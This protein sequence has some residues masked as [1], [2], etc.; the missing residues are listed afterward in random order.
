MKRRRVDACLRAALDDKRF[1]SFRLSWMNQAFDH[2]AFLRVLLFWCFPTRVWQNHR[3]DISS[4]CDVCWS[5]SA[6]SIWFLSCVSDRISTTSAFDWRCHQ[7]F[8]FQ[9]AHE[10][11]YSS[12]YPSWSS[13]VNENLYSCRKKTLKWTRIRCYCHWTSLK[14]IILIN[15]L[16][17]NCRRCADNVSRFNWHV[18]FVH[19]WKNE[20]RSTC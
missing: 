16:V 9:F 2:S 13:F 20:K 1:S 17:H 6:L 11:N 4:F 18:L 8:L 14:I 3:L 5:A 10:L 15:R 12:K 7:F 19:S